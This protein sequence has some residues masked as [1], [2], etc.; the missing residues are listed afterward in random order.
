LANLKNRDHGGATHGRSRRFRGLRRALELNLKKATATAKHAK[1][2]PIGEKVGFT[3]RENPLVVSILFFSR[4][5]RGSR[6]ELPV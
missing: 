3:Q 1:T 6:F 4:I 5:S 2:E